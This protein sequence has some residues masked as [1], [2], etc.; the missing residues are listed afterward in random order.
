MASSKNSVLLIDDSTFMLRTIDSMLGGTEFNVVGKAR[1]TKEGLQKFKELKPEIVL[2]DIVL[3]DGLGSD[4]LVNILEIDKSAAVIMVSSLGTQQKVIEC[5][6]KGAKHFI[7]K[8]FEH[9]GLLRVLRDYKH[10]GKAI[11]PT[12][13]V[14][15]S[16][17]GLNL[18]MKFF[19]QYLLERGSINAEQLIK[20]VEYQKQ[21]NVSLEAMFL[22][23]GL[24]SEDQVN[25]INTFQK[26]DLSREFGEI[27]ITEGFLPKEKL[28]QVLAEQKTNRIYI[29]ESLVQ[30]GAITAET[31]ATVLQEYKEEQEKDEWHIG[32]KLEKVKNTLIVKTFISFTMKMF[33]KVL[34]ETVKLKACLASVE[35]FNLR[36]YTISQKAKGEFKGSFVLNMS[37]DVAYKISATFFKETI[38][39]ITAKEKDAMK[40]FLNIIDGNCCSK[41]SNAGVNIE[42]EPPVFYYNK[43]GAQYELPD[44]VD[45]AFASLISTIGDFDLVLTSEK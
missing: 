2:L 25:R 4:L 12:H 11:T 9:E 10:I 16:F 38:D 15:L 39:K 45:I 23:K 6:K 42:T 14:S 8:P 28:Q 43:G 26:K 24:L 34:R 40:E 41:L 19:G 29:G 3:P 17:A 30:T 13:K 33:E 27:V 44:N 32:E 18:G 36:D 22:S 20:A 1:S 31:L 5:L 35:H 7:T 21:V 37:G